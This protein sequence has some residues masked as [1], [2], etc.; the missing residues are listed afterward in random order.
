MTNALAHY[1][2]RYRALPRLQ[3]ELATLGLMLLLAI[4]LLPLAIWIAGQFF[5]GDYIR[6][7]SGSPTGGLGAFWVD[8]MAG[9]L[10]GSPGYW[11][12]LLGPWILLMAGRGAVV[13]TRRSSGP[14]SR[15]NAT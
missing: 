15:P 4:T 7:P 5:L 12:V 10:G 14:G 2:R 8:Y 11:M 13:L 6:D 1:W 3:R 9:I